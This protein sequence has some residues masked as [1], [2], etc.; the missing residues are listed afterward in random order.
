MIFAT[1]RAQAPLKGDPAKSET[2]LARRFSNTWK[3]WRM[4]TPK[5]GMSPRE[6]RDAALRS[7]GNV[8]AVKMRYREQASFWMLD[9]FVQDVR[10]AIRVLLRDRAFAVTAVLVLGFGIGVNNMLFTMVYTHTMRGLPVEQPRSRLAHVDHRSARSRARTF[11]PRVRRLAK[12]GPQLV[13]V[14]AFSNRR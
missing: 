9:A 2:S 14:A 5:R 12:G 4:S 3:C 1:R 8:E 10:F 11:L 7:F 6:A 13:G